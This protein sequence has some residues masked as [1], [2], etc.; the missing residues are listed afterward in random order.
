[1]EKED[2]WKESIEEVSHFL[3]KI[4]TF[5]TSDSCQLDIQRR[6]KDE[7]PLDHNSTMNTILDLNY[8]E[9][10]IRDEIL[11]LTTKNYIETVKDKGREDKKY[12]RIFTKKI[13]NRET[14]IKLKIYD[15]NRIHLMSFHYANWDMEDRPYK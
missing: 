13:N 1:M 9:E 11:S 6:R 7:D 3:K 15:L 14:Y 12:Y 8:N 10:D 2:S 4:H 5:L